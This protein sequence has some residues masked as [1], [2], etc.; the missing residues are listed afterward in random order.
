MSLQFPTT[1]LETLIEPLARKC[2]RPYP[3]QWDSMEPVSETFN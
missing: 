3:A 2:T 1:W